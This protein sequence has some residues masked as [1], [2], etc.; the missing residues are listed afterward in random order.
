MEATEHP[1]PEEPQPQPQQPPQEES[2]STPPG[3]KL[4]NF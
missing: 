2:G 1:K 4:T 3:K